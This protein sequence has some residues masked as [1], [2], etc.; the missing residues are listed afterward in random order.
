MTVEKES[1]IVFVRHPSGIQPVSIDAERYSV[2]GD[3]IQFW[4]GDRVVGLFTRSEVL[5][6]KNETRQPRQNI[7][8]GHM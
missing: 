5:G 7:A 3:H 6:L 2:E 4:V 1:Y 8:S